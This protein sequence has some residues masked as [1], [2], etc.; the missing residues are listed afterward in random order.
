MR[1][2]SAFPCGARL[3]YSSG[4]SVGY[5]VPV[6]PGLTRHFHGMLRRVPAPT[7]ISAEQVGTFTHHCVTQI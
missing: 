4:A 5:F 3:D 6:A 2:T 1:A 7:Q